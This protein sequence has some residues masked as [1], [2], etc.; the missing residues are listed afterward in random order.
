MK[1]VDMTSDDIKYNPEDL[2]C[3]IKMLYLFL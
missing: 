3:L 1:L 2:D